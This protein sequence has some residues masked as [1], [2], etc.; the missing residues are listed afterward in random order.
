MNGLG[1]RLL[2]ECFGT[3]AMVFAGT[4]AIVVNQISGGVV[5]HVGVSLV[6]GLVV[7]AMIEVIGDVSGAHINPAVTLAF[8]VA[9]RFKWRDVLSYWIAQ[10]GGAL[11]ASSLLRWLYPESET[12]GATLPAGLASH[13]FVIEVLLGLMLMYAILAVSTGARER[14][15]S[16]AATIGAVVALEALFA[17]PATG[18]S[19]NPARSLAPALVSGHLEHLW[20]YLVAPPLGMLLAVLLFGAIKGRNALAGKDKP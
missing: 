8:A 12:L 11:L 18:A 20:L 5:T 2:A 7:F 3:F 1:K 14:G 4:G 13:A 16:A 19:M 15:S 6:F 9:G 17:G 10:I